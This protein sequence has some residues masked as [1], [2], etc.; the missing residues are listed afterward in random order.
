MLLLGSPRVPESQPVCLRQNH[1]AEAFTLGVEEGV[2]KESP[3]VDGDAPLPNP[4][5][6]DTVAPVHKTAVVQPLIPGKQGR[7]RETLKEPD[8]RLVL[9]SLLSDVF[10]DL[11]YADAPA[12][13]ALALIFPNVLIEDVHPLAGAGRSL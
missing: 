4:Q 3:S 8:Q 2:L 13:E 1:A 5:T 10:A 7:T 11:A 12:S 9:Y 6:D